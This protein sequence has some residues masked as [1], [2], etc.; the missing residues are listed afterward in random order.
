MKTVIFIVLIFKI[1]CWGAICY[2]I[3]WSN[4][5]GIKRTT[6]IHRTVIQEPVE[7]GIS[8][9][10]NP[11]YLQ[12]PL[13]YTDTT[14]PNQRQSSVQPLSEQMTKA[15]YYAEQYNLGASRY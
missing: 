8:G 7:N 5:F 13:A 6:I 4:R 1:C 11:G 14:S 10:E 9:I 2:R 12:Q 15:P 3:R